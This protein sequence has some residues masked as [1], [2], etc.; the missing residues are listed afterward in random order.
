MVLF[1]NVAVSFFLAC[2]FFEAFEILFCIVS[3][4]VVVELL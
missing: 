1:V 2:V 3:V 4:I